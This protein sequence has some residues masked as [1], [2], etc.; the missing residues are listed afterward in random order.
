MCKR[1][2]DIW[3][4]FIPVG[5]R[6]LSLPK[7]RTVQWSVVDDLPNH[8]G[9]HCIRRSPADTIS[10]TAPPPDSC[11]YNNQWCS[12]SCITPPS[13][14]I[15]SPTRRTEYKWM[16][17]RTPSKRN[18][19]SIIT[20][21][22]GYITYNRMWRLCHSSVLSIWIKIEEGSRGTWKWRIY[23]CIWRTWYKTMDWCWSGTCFR[24]G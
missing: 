14:S 9:Y 12:R 19:Y 18:I 22:Q 2:T 7:Q 1:W 16:E 10:F 4:V 21:K 11:I 24:W 20:S 17:Y 3:R 15:Q 8:D 13:G 6:G 5:N 23:K